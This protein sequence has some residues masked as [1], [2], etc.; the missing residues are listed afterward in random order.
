MKKFYKNK[1]FVSILLS[2]ILSFAFVAVA[3]YAATTIG[4]N[5]NTGGTL[6]VTGATA[7]Y[8][9]TSI[10][11]A[12]TAT[13]TLAVS[14]A[15][16]FAGNASTT[17]SAILKSATI[18]SDTG[19]ISFGDENLSTSGTLTLSSGALSFVNASSTGWLKAATINSDTGAISFG[20]ENLTTTGAMNFA[21]ASSTGLASLD[22]IKVS[23]VGDTIS[24]IQFGTCTVTIGSV[25]A[26]STAVA[27]C[28]ATGVTTSHQV[29]VTP[30]IT[31]PTIIFSSASSTAD[32]IIQVAVY[33]TGTV[34]AVDPADNSWA[35]MAIK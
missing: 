20:N 3:A 28:A 16:S 6:T 14:G 2:V 30:Y 15:A 31:N 23:S 9:A 33:N 29:F 17:G 4:T 13:S 25:T 26:S 8:G 11:G 5:V 21:T 27:N 18:N 19:A 10:G 22:S 32:N 35:W 7:I 24:D 12:L 1:N 34:G